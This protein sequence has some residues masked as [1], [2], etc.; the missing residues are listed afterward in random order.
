MQDD[1][2]T[3]LLRRDPAALDQLIDQHIDQVHWLVGLILGRVGSPMGLSRS[4]IDNRLW[5]ARQALRD[6]LTALEGVHEMG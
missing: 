2:H 6:A 1:L 5:R 4:A 3:R